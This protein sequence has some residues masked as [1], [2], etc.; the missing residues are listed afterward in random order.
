M[1]EPDPFLESMM[2][3][4]RTAPSK[5]GKIGRWRTISDLQSNRMS[6]ISAAVFGPKDW[7][8]SVVELEQ[9]LTSSVLKQRA[10]QMLRHSSLER[11]LKRL[12]IVFPDR[13]SYRDGAWT[14]RQTPRP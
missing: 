14:I 10:K 11:I 2:A 12:A 8:G 9:V 1:S 7:I 4:V 3:A 5:L 13:V 6:I